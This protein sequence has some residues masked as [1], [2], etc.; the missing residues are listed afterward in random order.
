[1]A[2][3]AALV[4]AAS[5]HSWPALDAALLAYP[6]R[7]AAALARL[8]RG[9]PTKFV[10]VGAHHG[11]GNREHSLLSAFA[12]AL[13]A[14]AALFVDWGAGQR[15]AGPRRRLRKKRGVCTAGTLDESYAAPGFA[16]TRL[17][18]AGGRPRVK[19]TSFSVRARVRLTHA[20]ERELVAA[21]LGDGRWNH[22]MIVTTDHHFLKA[23]LC[24]AGVRVSSRRVKICSMAHPTHRSVSTQA[25]GLFPPDYLA[26][27]RALEAFLLRPAARVRAAVTMALKESSGCGVGVHLRKKGPDWRAGGMW[28]RLR[29]VVAAHAGGLLIGS[30][31]HSA[32]LKRDLIALARADNVSVVAARV[33]DPALEALVE[34]HLFS[35]C[36]FLIPTRGSTFFNVAVVR[37]TVRDDVRDILACPQQRKAINPF[38]GRP[39][40][41]M[42]DPSCPAVL[43]DAQF[44][45]GSVGEYKPRSGCSP[46][47]GGCAWM[48]TGGG[49]KRPRA[50]KHLGGGMN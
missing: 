7:H 23:V 37:A 25:S 36:A 31:G 1:M 29:R 13:A 40:P 42:F 48:R 41:C 30:D 5:A 33:D 44:E 50:A 19:G 39:L 2:R 15:C 45:R 24:N 43:P 27:Q 26:A 3:V 4:L 14:D 11:L 32:G 28:P 34:N 21:D 46:L 38:D 22:S 35:A 12:L 8:E 47:H 20:S 9:A 16:W 49:A 17:A 6:A 18:M 10:L